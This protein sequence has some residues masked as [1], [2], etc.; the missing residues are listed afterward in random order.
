MAESLGYTTEDW[1]PDNLI[2]GPYPLVT[3][4]ITLITGQDLSRG[5]LLG[6]ITDGGKYT[7]SLSAS[8]D[9]S[10]T[11]IAIL[12][13]DTD[14]S[15]ADVETIAY[16]AGEFNENAM[17]FGDDHTADTVRDDLR[18]LNMYLKAPVASN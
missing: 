14:A 13:K 9:G 11:P 8:E 16:I 5:A 3:R 12:A 10:E 7:L 15:L 18:A 17:T 4:E 1:S 6:K 2:A